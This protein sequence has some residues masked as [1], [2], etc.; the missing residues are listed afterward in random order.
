M[1]AKKPRQIVIRL[2]RAY[3]PPERTDGFRVLVD[4]LWPRGLTKSSARIDLWLKEL[5]P[6]T[7]LRNWFSHDPSRWESFR[8]RYFRELEKRPEAVQQLDEHL[9]RG[10]V[11]L[12]FAAK[13]PEYNNAVALKEYIESG[14]KQS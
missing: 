1:A 8:A 3:E 11:T 12:V 7:A 2:K 5:G 10:A 6:S 13:D 14:R 4:R 9:R